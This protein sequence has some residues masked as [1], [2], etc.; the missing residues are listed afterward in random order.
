MLFSMI[1]DKVAL[2]L[3]QFPVLNEL[4]KE[5]SE[6]IRERMIRKARNSIESLRNQLRMKIENDGERK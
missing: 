4:G 5:A 2:K 3:L 6:S 1:F